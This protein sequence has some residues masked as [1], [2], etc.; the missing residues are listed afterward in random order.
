MKF[1]RQSCYKI[2]PSM[3]IFLILSAPSFT[4]E[5]E[6][7]DTAGNSG[8]EEFEY[9]MEDSMDEIDFYSLEALLDVEVEV[10]SLFIED[11]LVV[12]STVSSITSEQW[13]IRGARR[14]HE[15][16]ENEMSVT[17]NPVMMGSYLIY[18]RGYTHNGTGKGVT[19]NLDGV[20]CSE[21]STGSPLY[22][23]PNWNLGTL[24]KIEMI[25]GPG[26]SIYG[27]DAFHGALSLKTFE[28]NQDH[29]SIEVAGAFPLYGDG[30]VKISQG[31]A[32]DLVR[33]DL[34]VSASYQDDQELE[35][36]Y[37]DELGYNPSD[38]P[39]QIPYGEGT[40]TYKYKYNTQSGVLKLRI[41]PSNKLNLKFGA[42]ANSGKYMTFPGVVRI[43]DG[44]GQQLHTQDND[45][46]NNETQFLM[47]NGAINYT[48]PNKISIEANGYYW[49]A[50]RESITSA[51]PTDFDIF[52]SVDE[53][54]N[55]AGGKI[56]IKQPENDLNLQ[57][58][59][60]YSYTNMNVV[61]SY[62]ETS[63]TLFGVTQIADF[64]TGPSLTEGMSRNIHS[65]F[66]QFKWGITSDNLFVLVGGRNDYYSDFGNQVTPRG[67][68]IYLPTE[69]SSIKA[70]YGRAFSAPSGSQQKDQEG[71]A[72]GNP[73]LDP[74]IIDIYELIFIHK[75]KK[76]KTSINTF[77]SRWKNAI[78]LQEAPELALAKFRYRVVN[79]GKNHAFGA[80]LNFFYSF[81]PFA[82]DL[83]FAY[84]KSR[85]LDVEDPANP[86]NTKNQVYGAFPE[87]FINAGFYYTLEPVNINFY[88]NNIIRLRTRE[89]PEDLGVSP[90][91]LPAYYRLDLNISKI[92]S[93]KLELFLN[94]R[95]ALNRE[96]RV[97]SVFGAEN[98]YLE[99]GISAMLRAEYKL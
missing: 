28:S 72:K 12:G 5:L 84:V 53:K 63:F 86:S 54:V 98:G 60:A 61:S 76:W 16:L 39:I 80:E 8:A 71:L 95:N 69:K 43:I 31:F 89:A 56:I 17:A 59:L 55:R 51:S 99:P 34:A 35:Y 79:K 83:R 44:E 21:L 77:Y 97:P 64:G 11:E 42:Y 41:N 36:D 70:L 10:A 7:P 92:I 27:S 65:V 47:A 4:Q 14:M 6:S 23:L 58:L 85:A 13:K 38:I 52:N 20:P 40:G 19:T 1:K 87:Y 3:A 91:F 93:K 45:F 82:L 18:I 22:F 66:G 46:S 29:Y 2:F 94:V 50:E 32:D 48:F 9:F 74:E 88:L 33:I 37:K 78:V 49:V 67:G 26:S 68:I 25:K 24:D 73:D 57:W 96:N 75:E 90:D 62:I 15:A 81:Q 30:N